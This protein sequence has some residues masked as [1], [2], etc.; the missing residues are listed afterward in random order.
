LW[1]FAGEITETLITNYILCLFRF[2]PKC[3]LRDVI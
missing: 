1:G 3:E 2:K